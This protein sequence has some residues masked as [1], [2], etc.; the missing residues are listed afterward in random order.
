MSAFPLSPTRVPRR[1]YRFCD[2]ESETESREYGAPMTSNRASVL[3][4]LV[5]RIRSKQKEN[6]I[7][8]DSTELGAL[9]RGKWSPLTVAGSCA[10]AARIWTHLVCC[11]CPR[12]GRTRTRA[13]ERVRAHRR[14]A[15]LMVSLRA[16]C[17]QT[18]ATEWEQKR[19][20]AL[21]VTSVGE[22]TETESSREIVDP[23]NCAAR[24]PIMT[25]RFPSARVCYVGDQGLIRSKRSS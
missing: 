2:A 25:P 22:A 3:I 1:V 19:E 18:E 21:E 6:T 5:S 16:N 11:G 8:R 9:A 23:N 20:C 17:R 4:S 7:P 24:S 12:H 13:Q 14:M 15:G 10:G